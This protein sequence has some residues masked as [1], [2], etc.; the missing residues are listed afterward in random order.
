MYPELKAYFENKDSEDTSFDYLYTRYTDDGSWE[1]SDENG[2]VIL[3]VY[4]RRRN[5]H[6]TR[7]F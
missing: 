5:I 6:C 2:D 7:C 3:R 4:E 1:N